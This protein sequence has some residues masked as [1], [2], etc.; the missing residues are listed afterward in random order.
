MHQRN[1]RVA[2]G[3]AVVLVT[4]LAAVDRA[5]AAGAVLIDACQTLSDAN[6]TYKL[7]TDLTS[8][9]SC[10]I[11]ANDKITID[12][13]GHSITSTCT[14]T[15]QSERSAVTDQRNTFNVITIKNGFVSRYD[16]GVFLQTSTRVSVL[17]VTAS[18]NGAGIVAGPQ[19][20]VK[21]SEAFRNGIGISVGPRGQVQ[22]SNSHDNGSVGIFTSGDNCLITASTA[23]G[24][25]FAGI[26]V[27]SKRCTISFNTANNNRG[28]GISAGAADSG[29][30]H[31]VTHN[32]ALNNNSIVGCLGVSACLVNS[33]NIDF[34]IGCPSTV[35]DN[36]STNGFPAS[37]DL[38]GTGCHTTNNN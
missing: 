27:E 17:A 30:G 9:D 11:V 33:S 12:L 29:S 19:S 37:Y 31:L 14:S 7:T 13:Q 15:S 22:Q 28:P 21:G 32:V 6:T 25:V 2:A 23:N 5:S 16:F 3:I 1:I 26:L 20:L 35:T 38:Q 34:R 4:T 18:N 36:D 24:N 8:C 10:L